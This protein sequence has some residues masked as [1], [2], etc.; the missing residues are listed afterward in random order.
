MAWITPTETDAAAFF[1]Q[2]ELDAFRASPAASM[3]QD[4]HAGLM[5]ATVQQIRAAVRACGKVKMAEDPTTI[6]QS[7]LATWA[8]IVRFHALTRLPV[9]VGE[10]RR[11]AYDAAMDVF[12]K[13]AAGDMAVE[14]A[15]DAEDAT[16]ATLPSFMPADPERRLG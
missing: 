6:P 11:K 2:K 12:K 14:P 10:D 9:P 15:D 13:V 16:S 4:P 5:A 1:S 7:L 3:D 8:V